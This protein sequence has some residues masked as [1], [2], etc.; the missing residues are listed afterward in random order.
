[1]RKVAGKD[2]GEKKEEGAKKLCKR[3]RSLPSSCKVK[4]RSA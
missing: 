3:I 1:M 4:R 2:R